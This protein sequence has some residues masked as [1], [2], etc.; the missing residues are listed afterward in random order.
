MLFL[1]WYCIE[2]QI[3]V[4]VPQEKGLK[5]VVI[6]CR[7]LGKMPIQQLFLGSTCYSWEVTLELA[8]LSR[9]QGSSKQ[10]KFEEFVD[11]Q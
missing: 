3:V 11:D 4:V 9:G 8:V 6:R 2:P 10:K 1:E 7:G 5:G